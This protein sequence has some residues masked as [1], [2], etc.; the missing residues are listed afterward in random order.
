M[1]IPNDMTDGEGYETH[2]HENE[3]TVLMKLEFEKLHKEYRVLENHRHKI[4]HHEGYV[5]KRTGRLIELLEQ[6]HAELTHEMQNATCKIHIK[7]ADMLSANM[8]EALRTFDLYQ[9]EIQKKMKKIAEIE[10][11]VDRITEKVVKQHFKMVGLHGLSRTMAQRERDLAKAEDRLY[12]V[13]NVYKL[14]LT[15]NFIIIGWDYIAFFYI[16]YE[17]YTCKFNVQIN[18]NKR[19]RDEIMDFLLE[20]TQFFNMHNSTKRQIGWAKKK[21]LNIVQLAIQTYDNRL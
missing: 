6:D 13:K 1:S 17:Q 14:K 3:Y 19:L 16:S 10:R 5:H 11:H 4:A 21:M 7:H 20:R 8:K 9:Q 12:H 2:K 18:E 15:G